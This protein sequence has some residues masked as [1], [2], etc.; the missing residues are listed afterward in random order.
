MPLEVALGNCDEVARLLIALGVDLNLPTRESLRYSADQR[1]WHYTA[2]DYARMVIT[3]VDEAKACKPQLTAKPAGGMFLG[4]PRAVL[5]MPHAVLGMPRA[6]SSR[7]QD[8]GMTAPV[9]EEPTWKTEFSKIAA[10]Y[11][12]AYAK[13]NG[14]VTVHQQVAYLDEIK[15]YYDEVS[16]LLVANQAKSATDIWKSDK[17]SQSKIHDWKQRLQSYYWPNQYAHNTGFNPPFQFFRH[18]LSSRDELNALYEELY[19]ACWDGDNAKIRKLCLPLPGRKSPDLP[20]QISVQWGNHW[21]GKFRLRSRVFDSLSS[22]GFSPVFV[23]LYRR[24][25]ETAKLIVAIAAAQYNPTEAKEKKYST[26]DIAQRTYRASL[27]DTS[28]GSFSQ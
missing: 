10:E 12:K 13:V 8:I 11:Q 22:T 26:H 4:M 27:G 15:A 6:V 18:G 19:T 16:E 1:D 28:S 3:K 24:H 17:S 25:W 20:L 21:Q 9:N 14:S 23:A 7:I 2:L 5:G